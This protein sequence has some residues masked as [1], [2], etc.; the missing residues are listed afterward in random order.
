[1][2][3]NM[4]TIPE[5]LSEI[6]PRVLEAIDRYAGEWGY[7]ALVLVLALASFGLGRLSALEAV[8]P[9]LAIRT[10][11]AGTEPS[12]LA[13]GGLVVASRQGSAYYFPWCTGAMRLAVANQIWF[14]SEQDA[15]RAGYTPA[16]AC[17]GLGN[18]L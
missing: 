11:A 14:A 7:V 17:Q 18:S 9:P 13:L 6:K 12:Q 5:V 10:T 16:K 3:L 8:Q 1:M 15:R 4:G 2:M